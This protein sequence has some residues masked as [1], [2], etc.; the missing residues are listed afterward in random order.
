MGSLI[1]AACENCGYEIELALGG[2]MMNFDM[3]CSS[4]ALNK[5]INRIEERNIF[6]RDKENLKIKNNSQ[7]FNFI[8][9]IGK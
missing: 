9:Q 8:D 6:K 1:T 3:N 5:T 4:P 2:G 7:T